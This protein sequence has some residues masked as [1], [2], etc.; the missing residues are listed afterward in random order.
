V[1][2]LEVGGERSDGCGNE[3]TEIEGHEVLFLDVGTVLVT[4]PGTFPSMK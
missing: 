3:A 2:D 1:V 4:F